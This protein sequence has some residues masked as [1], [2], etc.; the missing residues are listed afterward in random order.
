MLAS[1]QWVQERGAR[2]SWVADLLVRLV[3]HVDTR[4]AEQVRVLAQNL[5]LHLDRVRIVAR[6]LARV[7]PGRHPSLVEEVRRLAETIRRPDLKAQTLIV[8]A[9]AMSR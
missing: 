2:H 7:A 5:P 3:P 9:I 6:L 1:I 8:L 4:D